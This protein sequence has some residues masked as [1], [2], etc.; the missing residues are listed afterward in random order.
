MVVYMTTRIITVT[1]NKGGVGKTATVVNLAAGLA[2]HQ[3]R[4]LVIDAD[5]QANTTFALL[6]PEAPATTLY[7]V[8]VVNTAAADQVVRPTP[9]AGID[10]I[11]SH[12]NLSA[13]DIV[14]AGVPGRERL[15][16][17]RLRSVI[18]YDYILID[19][20]H[21]WEYSRSTA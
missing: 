20:P 11:P 9:A 8:L 15:L 7:D 12:I 2:L 6:G 10:L 21:R 4:V 13:A 18:G 3:R 16:S 17:R 5:P 19:T 14:L 1:N